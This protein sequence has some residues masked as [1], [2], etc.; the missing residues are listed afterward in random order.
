MLGGIVIVAALAFSDTDHDDVP[1][2]TVENV[3]RIRL[4]ASA[5]DL[6]SHL[7]GFQDRLLYARFAFLEADLEAFQNS[8]RCRLSPIATTPIEAGPTPAPAWW[9][10]AAITRS[11]TC[12][13]EGP[14]FSQQIVIDV[15]HSPKLVG[16]LSVFE[17]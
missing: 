6:R 16:Y 12:E 3:G 15:S 8:L 2:A 5:H 17:R 11:R 4:P 7:E 13:A 10:I 14:G 1:R 9:S